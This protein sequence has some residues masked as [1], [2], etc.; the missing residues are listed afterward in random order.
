VEKPGQFRA[1][2][3]NKGYAAVMGA[4]GVMLVGGALAFRFLPAPRQ[5]SAA[6]GEPSQSSP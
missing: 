4:I 6:A 2:I 3:N 5:A 1:E